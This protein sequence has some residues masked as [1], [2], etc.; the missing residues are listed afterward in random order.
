VANTW[1]LYMSLNGSL[2]MA[3]FIDALTSGATVDMS[4]TLLCDTAGSSGQLKGVGHYVGVANGIDAFGPFGPNEA[5][6][7][8]TSTVAITF[9]ASATTTTTSDSV[10]FNSGE[11]LLIG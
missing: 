3:L 8:L 6:F 11:Y 4:I 1:S 5:T 9:Q 7:D 2:F 10:T